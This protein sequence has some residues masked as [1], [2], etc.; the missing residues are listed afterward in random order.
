[1][2]IFTAT[3]KSIPVDELTE[4]LTQFQAAEQVKAEAAAAAALIEQE[5]ALVAI[6]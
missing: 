4:V 2:D 3:P 6:V 5:A 1:M